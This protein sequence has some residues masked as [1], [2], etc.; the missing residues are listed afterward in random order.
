LADEGEYRAHFHANFCAA[1]LQLVNDGQGILVYFKK[2]DFD[3]AFYDRSARGGPKDQFSLQRACR[4]PMIAEALAD[5]QNERY[6]GW[7]KDK[8]A[9]D[10]TRC[11]CVVTAEDFVVVIRLGLTDRG[12]LRG[13]F[14]TCYFADS[15]STITQIRQKPA[16]DQGLCEANLAA[17][18]SRR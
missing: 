4:M 7:D 8:G 3:H 11:V 13:W 5:D 2:K 9:I 1:P 17:Q 12:E 18:R 6:Q 10:S 15:P 14:V 16:W